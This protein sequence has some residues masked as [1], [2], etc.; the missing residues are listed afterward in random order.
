[1]GHA[2]ALK[3]TRL[4]TQGI[5]WL[6]QSF[7]CRGE[8]KYIPAVNDIVTSV[9]SKSHTLSYLA[10]MKDFEHTTLQVSVQLM[11]QKKKKLMFPTMSRIVHVFLGSLHKI[12]H[13][14]GKRPQFASI[15]SLWQHSLFHSLA[16]NIAKSILCYNTSGSEVDAIKIMPTNKRAEGQGFLG[17]C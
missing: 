13:T 8:W 4:E 5:Y 6:Q 10:K 17:L 11:I 16:T 1:M 7:C 12:R 9:A 2:L 3:D 15:I 14:Y